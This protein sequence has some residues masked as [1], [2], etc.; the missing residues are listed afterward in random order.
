MR[1]MTLRVARERRKLTVERLAVLAQVHR[2]TIYR[3]EA[4]STPNPGSV[5]V[6]KLEAALGV[7]PGT[8]VFRPSLEA[9]AS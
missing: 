2:A 7:P 9:A 8:L 5:T 4:M 1:Q 6:G 3:L